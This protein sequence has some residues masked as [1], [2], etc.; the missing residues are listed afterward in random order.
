MADS[1]SK[2][3]D[4]YRRRLVVW[5]SEP[6][7]SRATGPTNPS[8][9]RSVGYKAKKEFIIVRVRAPKGRR[10]RPQAKLGRKSGKN[11]KRVSP[12]YSK[13]WLCEQRALRKYL[14]L[15]VV[16]SYF[17]GMDGTNEYYEVVMCQ[18]VSGKLHLR[19][20]AAASPAPK[21]APGLTLK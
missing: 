14:N 16:G 13:Q 10:I 18:K 20:P 6:T 8:S 5:K 7:V 9:A 19:K 3:S 21:A 15:R 4:S 12:A 17:V 1:M 11:Q 2:R